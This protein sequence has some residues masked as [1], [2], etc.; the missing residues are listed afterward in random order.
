MA[1]E[2][3]AV[4]ATSVEVEGLAEQASSK[5]KLKYAK[6]E[7]NGWHGTKQA[8]FVP[9]QMEMDKALLMQVLS[10]LNLPEPNLLLQPVASRIHP[11]EFWTSKELQSPGMSRLREMGQEG[12]DKEQMMLNDDQL[13]NVLLQKLDAIFAGVVAAVSQ[14]DSWLILDQAANG[15]SVII[16]ES[17]RDQTADCTVANF[18]SALPQEEGRQNGFIDPQFWQMLSTLYK[19]SKDLSKDAVEEFGNP[20]VFRSELLNK[21][22]AFGLES[23]FSGFFNTAEKGQKGRPLEE[24]APPSL[25]MQ[26][27]A[28]L[29]LIKVPANGIDA[30][31]HTKID[32][33]TGSIMSHSG[34]PF[35]CLGNFGSLFV[36]GR[37]GNV[38]KR[39]MS[40]FKA[41]E[42]CV[43]VANTGGSCNSCACIVQAIAS[44][45]NEDSKLYHDV[46]MLADKK[47]M[48]HNVEQR[49]ANVSPLLLLNHV[50]KEAHQDQGEGGLFQ[51][52]HISFVLDL[53]RS[54]PTY[55]LE[56]VKVV[57]PLVDT[58]ETCIER[59]SVCLSNTFVAL[60]FGASTTHLDAVLEAWRN[61]RELTHTAQQMRRYA[62]ILTYLGA[63]SSWLAIV[64]SLILSEIEDCN[65]RPETIVCEIE[66]TFQG[67]STVPRSNVA[68][69]QSIIVFFPLF[70]GLVGAMTSVFA[71]QEKWAD[72]HLRAAQLIREI[73]L[74]RAG[75]GLYDSSVTNE[76]ENAAQASKR[77]RQHFVS[78]VSNLYRSALHGKL[79]D[80]SF[81]CP[82]HMQKEEMADYILTELYGYR[83][84]P[85]FRKPQQ[86]TDYVRM[87]DMEVKSPDELKALDDFVSPISA[88]VYYQ[89]RL[90]PLH[91]KYKKSAPALARQHK[92][93][94]LILVILSFSASMLG[95]FKYSAWIPTVVGLSSMLVFLNQFH[96]ARAQLLVTNA[97]RGTLRDMEIQWVSSSRMERR[98]LST[99]RNLVMTVESQELAVAQ[100]IAGSVTKSGMDSEVS[101]GE[102]KKQQ[103][104]EHQNHNTQK[105]ASKKDK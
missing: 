97:A 48:P 102:D 49:L 1:Q 70:G 103:Q 42:A 33:T 88:E 35:E 96:G 93:N 45:I 3:S 99:K 76:G 11:R 53:A 83:S 98:T 7:L 91:M 67:N 77:V 85:N 71:F 55:F 44:L 100:A 51:V 10:C 52:E 68:F 95:A 59:L 84:D 57:D 28:K 9:E 74:F 12:D 37:S 89:T 13:K 19:K 61:H 29:F 17:L 39:M 31:T 40:C 105:N 47:H 73:Y 86:D 6:F 65:F 5:P 26:A 69:V 94:N 32:A 63:L 15:S 60:E 30:D 80:D 46:A 58:P 24:R 4:H 92:R 14:T 90:L 104:N 75:L 81:D 23:E 62:T 2:E 36:G 66:R 82:G 25:F 54:R 43:I 79:Q 27:D 38:V 8:I 20:I 18:L 50:N 22:R 87:E 101:Q 41:G 72:L 21:V 64:T 56:N 16:N 34:M 78:R